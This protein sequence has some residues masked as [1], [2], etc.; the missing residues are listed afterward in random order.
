MNKNVC[1]YYNFQ[2]FFGPEVQVIEIQ[3]VKNVL[4]SVNRY[5]KSNLQYQPQPPLIDKMSVDTM[6]C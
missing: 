3:K 5:L 4:P 2:S 1:I 6:T